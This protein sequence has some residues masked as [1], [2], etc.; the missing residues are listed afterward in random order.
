MRPKRWTIS[1]MPCTVSSSCSGWSVGHLRQPGQL[2]VHL[3]AVLHGAGAESEVDVDVGAHGH[4][5]EA[6]VV[7]Q[8]LGL[9][10][11]GQ[12]REARRA[13]GRPAPGAA[14]SPTT[15]RMPA[16]APG[17]STPRSPGL[18][19]SMM[20]RLVPAGRVEP[21]VQVGR[22]SVHA[23]AI[24]ARATG[25]AHRT[26]SAT[27]ATKSVEVGLRVHLGD[28]EQGALTQLG[29]LRRRGP[30]RPKMPR[31]SRASFISATDLPVPAKST[32]NSLK[33]ARSKRRRRHA[34][35]LAPG[36]A[37]RRPTLPMM[38]SPTSRMPCGPI[39]AR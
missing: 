9:A 6:Q 25:R 5:R 17:G 28:A 14:G 4:L 36:A 31:S 8:H 32:V 27:V 29:E 37:P 23:A 24:A 34:G 10:E 38:V 1:S 15:A 20:R 30:C 21:F 13:A 16:P 39:S 12:V 26:T 11:L 19:S 18:P 33:K 22:A 35:H 2:L 3:G 7:T